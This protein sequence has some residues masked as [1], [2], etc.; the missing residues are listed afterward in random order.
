[1]ASSF[2]QV[3]EQVVAGY[4][5]LV[6]HTHEGGQAQA[7]LGG[8]LDD[9]NP[10]RAALRE[11]PEMPAGRK[12]GRERGVQADGRVRIQQTHAVRAH[13]SHPV[14]REPCR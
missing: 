2:S 5:G 4:V 12:D 14:A 6:P 1:M 9:G 10:Q 7:A 11:K 8:Q 3:L 13:H